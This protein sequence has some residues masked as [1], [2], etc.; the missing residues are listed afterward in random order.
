M[1]KT[2]ISPNCHTVIINI[3]NL[4]GA[5]GSNGNTLQLNSVQ[6][7][8]NAAEAASRKSSSFWDSED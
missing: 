7:N 2:Y 8:G 6:S 4:L 5:V 3:S 1:K